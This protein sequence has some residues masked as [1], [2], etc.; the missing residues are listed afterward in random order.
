MTSL[1]DYS[2]KKCILCGHFYRLKR[3]KKYT[4]GQLRISA[5]LGCLVC[6]YRDKKEMYYKQLLLD[7]ENKVHVEGEWKKSSD[8]SRIAERLENTLKNAYRSLGT[9]V[10]E[11]VFFRALDTYW[12]SKYFTLEQN[13][14]S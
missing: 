1:S 2:W 8:D 11:D 5:S 3:N 13:R 4:E 14:R 6:N 7:L 12:Y 10:A 9:I